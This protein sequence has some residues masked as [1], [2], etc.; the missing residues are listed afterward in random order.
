MSCFSRLIGDVVGL[1]NPI[2]SIDLGNRKRD[3]EVV[4]CLI[5]FFFFFFFPF[6]TFFFFLIKGIGKSLSLII[7]FSC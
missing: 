7:S 5:I 4:L 6:Y 1:G 2:V 3:F